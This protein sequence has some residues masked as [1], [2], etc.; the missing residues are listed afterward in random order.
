MK[1][2]KIILLIVITAQISCGYPKNFTRDFYTR[3]ESTLEALRIDFK[4]LYNQKPFALLFE[5]RT[6][7]YI[8]FEFISDTLK[9]IYH[10]NIN[11]PALEDS[12]KRYGY[13]YGGILKLISE[14]KQIQCTW[15]TN[16]DYY[17]DLQQRYLVLMA[18]RN[19]ALN[20]TFKGE[21]YCTLA[22]FENPQ[23]FDENGIFLDRADRKRRR[24]INGYILHKVNDNVGYAI[25]K[26]YR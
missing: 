13:N 4:N 19:N 21:S 8:N 26:Y 18:V 9:R 5:E 7:T 11:E 6:F 24:Q 14:M 2:S 12:L 3:N 20:K 16:L 25:T 22:F 23:P 15:L 1:T 10:F 17:E